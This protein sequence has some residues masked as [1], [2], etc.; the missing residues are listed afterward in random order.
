[1]IPTV[2]DAMAAKFLRQDPAPAGERPVKVRVKTCSE[3]L[4]SHGAVISCGDAPKADGDI[5]VAYGTCELEMYPSHAAKLEAEWSAKAP[6]K[7]EIDATFRDL[8]GDLIDV[9]ALEARR[10]HAIAPPR[11]AVVSALRRVLSGEVVGTTKKHYRPS[12]TATFQSANRREWPVIESV[13]I[14][15]EEKPT[16]P[17]R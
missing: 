1:M 10:N 11:S 13:E 17:K 4:V 14:V 9:G 3:N 15:P 12:W 6:T 16:T 7:E 5:P 2:S 8:E